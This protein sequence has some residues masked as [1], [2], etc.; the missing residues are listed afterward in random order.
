MRPSA[1]NL[2][3]DNHE[4]EQRAADVE[5]HLHDV[6]PDDRAHAALERIEQCER[7]NQQDGP[8]LGPS[9]HAEPLVHRREYNANHNRK[10]ERPNALRQR[11]QDEEGA[12]GQ[13]A[14]AFTESPLHQ[15]IGCEHLAA[16]VVR[17]EERRDDN[18]SEQISEHHLQ[19]PEIA[20]ERKRGCADH[21]ECAGF[22]RHD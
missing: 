3:K 8:G 15:L 20:P 9:G 5:K 4:A 13:T 21:R 22:G 14:H 11:S 12:C 7:E 18:A 19:E 17:K 16:K 2:A 6:G 10:C 1:G